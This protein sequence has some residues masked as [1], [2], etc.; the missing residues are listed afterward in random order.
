MYSYIEGHAVSVVKNGGRIFYD[1]IWVFWKNSFHDRYIS[2]VCFDA[3]GVLRII[4]VQLFGELNIDNCNIKDI[5]S[6]D[7]V[8]IEVRVTGID[9]ICHED[10]DYSDSEIT[11][12]E[13]GSINC[14]DII[15]VRLYNYSGSMV[16]REIYIRGKHLQI[17]CEV[18][19]KINDT[20]KWFYYFLKCIS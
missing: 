19:R 6:D 16:Y 9:Y 4:I 20:N 2:Q 5:K 13:V 18:I 10:S 8:D 7:Q 11:S 17:E 3:K 12:I 14:Y 1:S 15:L